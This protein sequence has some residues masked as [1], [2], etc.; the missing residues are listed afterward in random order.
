[1]WKDALY[2]LHQNIPLSV[3]SG[4]RLVRLVTQDEEYILTIQPADT[5]AD[6]IEHRFGH[7]QLAL[8]AYID[9]VGQ[10]Q[11]LRAVGAARYAH[12]FPLDSSL[13][14]PSVPLQAWQPLPG[15]PLRPEAFPA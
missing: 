9:V 5:S 4:G 6:A 12:L 7:P 11:L 3:I 2:L 14:W 8:L 13:S 1:M 10:G 15:T